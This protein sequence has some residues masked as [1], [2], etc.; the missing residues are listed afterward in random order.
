[1]AS[2][3]TLQLTILTQ[4]KQMLTRAV[5]SVSVMTVEGEVTILP[6][7]IPLFTKLDVG[8]LVFRWREGND[9]LESDSFSVSGGFLDV[10]PLGEVTIL[11]DY[12]IRSTDIDQAQAEEARRQAQEAMQNKQS[13]VDFRLAE[14]SLKRALNDLRVADKR[15][16]NGGM[17]R[18]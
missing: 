9:R 2:D 10:N 6:G 8:E 4:E 3:K 7:H 16:G 13:E 1:M 14:A 15:R 5:E 18:V 12:A 11:A 17:P